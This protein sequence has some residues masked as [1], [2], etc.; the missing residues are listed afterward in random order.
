[1]KVLIVNNMEPFVWGGGEE[2]AVN[3]QRNIIAAGHSAELLRIPFAYNPPENIVSQMLMCQNLCLNNVDKVIALKFPAYMIPHPNKT[4]WILHQFRQV[5]D[6]FDGRPEMQELKKLITKADNMTFSGA[7]RLFTNSNITK[8]RLEK[9]NGIKSKVL[10]PPVNQPE[11]FT[12]G[13]SQAYIFAGG[14]INEM[15]RQYLL[16]EALAKTPSNVR[17]IIAGPPDTEKDKDQLLSLAE[18]LEVGD[19]LK[20][21]L[22]FLPREKIADY[23]N[24]AQACAYL[25]LDEDSLGYVSMEAA[26]AGKAIITGADSGGLLNLV[27]NDITGWVVQPDAFELASVMTEAICNK[28]RTLEKGIAAR[29]LWNSFGATWPKTVERLLA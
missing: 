7:S 6:L 18:K 4:F 20:L 21:D 26:T 14:R 17:L 24:G 23:V 11:L 1:M 2:L 5:Y 8:D 3:L 15:K 25:P 12:G 9:Y 27:K 10:L 19:R 22:G 28:Q 13:D 29:S 16:I